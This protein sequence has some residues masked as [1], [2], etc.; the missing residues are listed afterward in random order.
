MSATMGTPAS[1]T[2]AGS[3]L[4]SASWGT[5]T[6]TMSAPWVARAWAWTRVAETSSV[7]VVVIDWMEMG[8]SPPMS[9][10]PRRMRR[11]GHIEA[12]TRVTDLHAQDLRLHLDDQVNGI[13]RTEAAVAQA[14]GDQFGDEQP[15]VVEIPSGYVGSQFAE[16]HAGLPGCLGTGG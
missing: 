15:E 11:E 3:A 12:R 10:V 14:V 8:A 7:L 9:T 16:G 4:A 2:I 13:A 6:R 5:A 1:A